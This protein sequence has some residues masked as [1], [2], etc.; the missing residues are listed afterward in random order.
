[1]DPDN[2]ETRRIW[3]ESLG[4]TVRPCRPESGEL[5]HL[6]SRPPD[7]KFCFLVAALL[8]AAALGGAF[9]SALQ[10]ALSKG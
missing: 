6:S 1:M 7:R 4:E 2:T 3:D 10:W 5:A 8:G 9:L